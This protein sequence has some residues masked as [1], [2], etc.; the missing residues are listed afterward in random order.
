MEIVGY[1]VPETEKWRV[2][3]DGVEMSKEEFWEK[4]GEKG[5]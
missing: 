4:H 3:V 2:K 5:D 1:Y